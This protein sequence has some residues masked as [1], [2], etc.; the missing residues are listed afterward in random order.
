MEPTKKQE[1]EFFS[2]TW[3]SITSVSY[4]KLHKKRGVGKEGGERKRREGRW[5]EGERSEPPGGREGVL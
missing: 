2:D 5:E 3:S 1:S 4:P